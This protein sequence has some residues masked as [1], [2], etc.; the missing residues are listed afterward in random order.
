MDEC[1]VRGSKT[2]MLSSDF[3]EPL[4]PFSL[5]LL[6]ARRYP[7]S[8]DL[9]QTSK[10]FASSRLP[11]FYIL[12]EHIFIP[13][14]QNTRIAKKNDLFRYRTSLSASLRYSTS[15]TAPSRYGNTSSDPVARFSQCSEIDDN[16][17]MRK[18]VVSLVELREV[19]TAFAWLFKISNVHIRVRSPLSIFE[20][21]CMHD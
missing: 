3:P 21:A 18:T 5:L 10:G 15:A 6:T 12:H 1:L 14:S 19:R 11:K 7:F 4:W 2:N 16:D 9:L 17:D 8:R 13:I 20:H